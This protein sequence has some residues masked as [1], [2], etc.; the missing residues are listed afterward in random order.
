MIRRAI[1]SALVLSPSAQPFHHSAKSGGALLCPGW[2]R[3]PL[4][5]PPRKDLAVIRARSDEIE[6][7][8]HH[9]ARACR[10]HPRLSCSSSASKTWMAGT[11]PA[12]TPE[13]WLNPTGICSKHRYERPQPAELRGIVVGSAIDGSL[14][15]F[16]P[17]PTDLS[18]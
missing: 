8:L 7:P 4:C 16:I 17:D 1:P 10:G 15:A 9:H 18:T 11:S 5:R 14:R 12:K 13:K 2:T 6:S 3:S